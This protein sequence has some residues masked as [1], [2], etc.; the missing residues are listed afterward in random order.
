[1]TMLEL[2]ELQARARAI[3]SQLAM[4]PVTKIEIDSDDENQG[5]TSKNP[6]KNASNSNSPSSKDRENTNSTSKSD[7]RNLKS[8]TNKK[9]STVTPDSEKVLEARNSYQQNSKPSK[10]IKLKRPNLGTRSEIKNDQSQSKAMLKSSEEIKKEIDN[11]HESSPDVI[12]MHPSP[13]TVLLSSDS[14]NENNL[15]KHSA[16]NPKNDDEEKISNINKFSSRKD[17]NSP[18]KLSLETEELDYDDHVSDNDQLPLT[19]ENNIEHKILKRQYRTNVQGELNA[20]VDSDKEER[21]SVDNESEISLSSE[22]ATEDWEDSIYE[23]IVNPDTNTGSRSAPEDL[24]EKLTRKRQEESKKVNICSKVEKVTHGEKDN[25]SQNSLA[26]EPSLTEKN[27][28]QSYLQTSNVSGNSDDEGF[29]KEKSSSHESNSTDTEDDKINENKEPEKQ[30]IEFTVDKL[31]ESTSLTKSQKELEEVTPTKIIENSSAHESNEKKIKTTDSDTVANKLPENKISSFNSGS[32]TS[33]ESESENKDDT[34]NQTATI[35]APVSADEDDTVCINVSSDDE[36]LTK[37][38]ENEENQSWDQR[39]LRSKKVTK[40]MASS[41]LGNK[42][43]G[44]IKEKKM[45]EKKAAEEKERLEE[46]ERRRQEE[47]EKKRQEVESNKNKIPEE[48][49]GSVHHFKQLKLL[50]KLK[51]EQQKRAEKEAKQTDKKRK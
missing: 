28:E 40:V 1:M 18:V 48:Q 43:R 24:R 46:V 17:T 49:M 33:R 47:E 13:E 19:A 2:L 10:R 21:A 20:S 22:S 37:E 35:Q 36:K 44:K 29:V 34:K 27:N 12:A 42:V 6:N 3:R 5:N 7:S 38:Y 31:D 11:E 25:P 14:D 8:K 32:E 30:N 15:S 41:K 23:G 16:Q 4:E 45:E 9:A 39:W 50:N 51:E 26:N